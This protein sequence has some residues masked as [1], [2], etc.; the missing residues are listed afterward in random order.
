[1]KR[2]EPHGIKFSPRK[3]GA[4]NVCPLRWA[5]CN[6]ALATKQDVKAF[7]ILSLHPF[8]LISILL[9]GLPWLL[10]GKEFTCNAEDACGRHGFGPWVRKIPWRRKWQPTS[11]FLPGNFHEQKNLAGYS[12]WGHK[13]V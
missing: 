7:M 10:S 12:P 6:L 3:D 4:K 2:G 5:K 8:Y 13:R 11:V 1:L 9:N